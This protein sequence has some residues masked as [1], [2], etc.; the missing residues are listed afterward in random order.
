MNEAMFSFARK[1]KAVPPDG[2]AGEAA[3]AGSE[4]PP[5]GDRMGRLRVHEVC[6]ADEQAANITAWYQ[7]YD[8]ISA[9][10]FHG[11]TS[12]VWL[13]RTQFYLERTNRALRQTCVVWPGAFWFGLPCYGDGMD[14]RVDIFPLK[15][16]AIVVRPGSVDFELLT[17]NVCDI[18]GIVI[19]EDVLARHLEAVGSP[20]LM[21][22]ARRGRVFSVGSERRGDFWRHLFRTLENVKRMSEAGGVP[23]TVCGVME[24]EI[25][26]GL[27]DLVADSAGMGTPRQSKLNRRK[28]V[29]RA[30]EYLLAHPDQVISITDLC[31]NLYVSRRT[32]QNCF[33]EVLGVCPLSYIKALRLNAVRRALKEGALC[34]SRTVQDVA[35]AHGFWHMSQFAADYRRQFQ[36]LPSETLRGGGAEDRGQKIEDR[37]LTTFAL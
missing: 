19:G 32:L 25:V 26:S 12:E 29:S 1:E 5:L 30:R 22:A 8:Q 36:E 21:E 9:G 20:E 37:A 24:E 16:D 11:M 4:I 14:A 27:I 6:D 2:S 34:G 7:E 23:E 33:Q 13:G 10:K 18:L 15:N 31:E 35:T 28:V 17:P 3:D